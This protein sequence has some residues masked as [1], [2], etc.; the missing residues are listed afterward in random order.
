MNRTVRTKYRQRSLYLTY[1]ATVDYLDQNECQT[2]SKKSILHD[3][4]LISTAT[5]A[6]DWAWSG[7]P[8]VD[9]PIQAA[10]QETAFSC[11]GLVFGGY[12]ADP[13]TRCQQYSVC[14]QVTTNISGHI[15]LELKTKVERRFA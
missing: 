5:A 6:A 11:A 14:L 10:V 4:T 12:Y 3:S 7:E 1:F 15:V 9:Y 13:E 8:D 2:K